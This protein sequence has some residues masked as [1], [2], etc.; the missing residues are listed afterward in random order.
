M[1]CMEVIRKHQSYTSIKGV[2]VPLSST[3]SYCTARKVRSWMNRCLGVLERTAER[4]DKVSE[5]GLLNN[6]W[7]IVVDGTGV[8]MPDT[9]KKQ[10]GWS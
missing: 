4:L 3:V 10:E 1:G 2:K 8:I 6:R 9:P 5:A 7:V